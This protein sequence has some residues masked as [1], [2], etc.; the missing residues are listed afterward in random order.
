MEPI[1]LRGDIKQRRQEIRAH[2][3]DVVKYVLQFK[4]VL[5]KHELHALALLHIQKPAHLCRMVR[6]PFCDV[7]ELINHPGYREFL[8]PKKKGRARKICAPDTVLRKAQ[9]HINY[10]LQAYYLWI[11]PPAAYGFVI[12]PHYLGTFC[13]IVENAR[14]HTG[15][16]Y[17]FNIDLKDFFDSI[18]ARQVKELFRSDLFDYNEEI[19]SALTFL[20]TYKGRLPTGAPTSP[21]LANFVCYRLDAELSALA[22]QY[23]FT[24][25]RYADDLTFSSN[26]KLSD[27]VKMKIT[28]LIHQNSFT[29]NEKKVYQKMFFQQQKVTGLVVNEKVNVDR[30]FIRKVRAIIHDVQLNGMD[31]A[32]MNHYNTTTPVTVELRAKFISRLEGYLSFIGQVRGKGDLL[33]LRYKTAFDNFFEL[34]VRNDKEEETD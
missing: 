21:V 24:Y 20:T 10:F 13:N 27:E 28:E 29:V 14:Q 19:A 23:A 17:V 11:K 1:R 3:G 9:K 34:S 16:K 25:T 18:T 33:Y 8:I 12:N 5:A 30:K 2:S 22:T 6:R 31:A 15:K 26:E 7:Q 4:D 32:V